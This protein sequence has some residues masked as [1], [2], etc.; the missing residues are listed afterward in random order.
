ME[1][2]SIVDDIE[3]LNDN[4]VIGNL[5]LDNASIEFKGKGN[6]LYC[7][8]LISLKNCKLRFTGNNSL[9]YFDEN[10]EPFSINI[11]VGND[12]V[13][14]IGK[15]CFFN[16]TSYFYATERKNVIIGNE[17]LM[18][19]G[20][21]LRTSDPHLI[22]DVETK[23]R[24]NFSKSILIGDH[25]WIGQN[26][27]LLKNT[28]IG[29]GT[30]IGGNSVV[31]GKKLSSNTIYAGNPVK[32]RK[33]GVFYKNPMSTH[34]YDLEKEKNSEIFDS[35]DYCYEQDEHTVDLEQIDKQLQQLHTVSEKI[36]Y[37]QKE[38][39]NYQYKNR[40]FIE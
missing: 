33:S 4:Q 2:V 30:I 21:Y 11:R 13:F 40:F 28:V 36:E 9:I 14:Y 19:F 8:E 34:D 18:S 5:K 3:Y 6:V 10:K 26:A 27:L 7:T 20:V 25:V 24:L 32:K 15:Q 12:S 17:C 16:K 23:K 31:S 35:D 22:Y 39:T 1:V 37:I 29:S 38:L